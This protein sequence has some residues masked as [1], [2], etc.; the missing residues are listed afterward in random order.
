[1]SGER[2]SGDLQETTLLLFTVFAAWMTVRLIKTP[3]TGSAAVA[4]LIAWIVAW[5]R[6]RRLRRGDVPGGQEH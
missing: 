6:L 3:S 2:R 5:D 4:G 1:M